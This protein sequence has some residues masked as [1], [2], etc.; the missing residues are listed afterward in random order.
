MGAS[1]FGERQR[2]R[3]WERETEKIKIG[4]TEIDRWIE[5]DRESEEVKEREKKEAL[6]FCT[7]CGHPT[8]E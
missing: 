6:E 3:E 8:L 1:L 5:K 7:F 4:K 2:Q